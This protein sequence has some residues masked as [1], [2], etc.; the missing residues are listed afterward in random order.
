MP[1]IPPAGQ[2][3]PGALGGSEFNEVTS[4]SDR[5]LGVNVV[6]GEVEDLVSLGEVSKRVKGCALTL[7]VQMD[8][9]IVKEKRQ[10]YWNAVCL[11]G[12]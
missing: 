5:A 3:D 1:S 12:D 9:S 7:G 10:P 6:A 11:D 4:Y 8:E 2:L